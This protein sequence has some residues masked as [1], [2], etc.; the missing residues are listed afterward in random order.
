MSFLEV[1]DLVV[2]YQKIFS[3]V[4]ELLVDPRVQEAYLGEGVAG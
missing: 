1:R 2:A 4:R 3:T